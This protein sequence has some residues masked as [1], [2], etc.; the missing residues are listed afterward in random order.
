VGT[1]AHSTRHGA[2]E[3]VLP[4]RRYRTVAGVKGTALSIGDFLKNLMKPIK[5][6]QGKATLSASEQAQAAASPGLF[7]STKSPSST[8]KKKK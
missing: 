4:V 1:T 3:N 8:G 5:P 6:Y 2:Q 7:P